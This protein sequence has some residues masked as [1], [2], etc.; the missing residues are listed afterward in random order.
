MMPQTDSNTGRAPATSEAS[1]SFAKGQLKAIIERIEKLEEEKK[2]ISDDIK[3]VYGE[4][5]GNGFRRQGAAH[6]HPH[7]AS[8]PFRGP[9]ELAHI[10]GGAGMEA[11]A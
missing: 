2:T 1:H 9:D 8:M 7:A 11:R 10:H 6:D 5:K 4:A 3:D